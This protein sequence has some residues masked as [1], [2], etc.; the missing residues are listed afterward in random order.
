MGRRRMAEYMRGNLRRIETNL[1]GGFPN[2]IEDRNK[3]RPGAPVTL[4]S[5]A[6]GIEVRMNGQ[7]L[8]ARSHGVVS[9]KNLSSGLNV[10]GH[11]IG[12][13]LVEVRP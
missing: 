11:L 7:V 8:T 6:S 1:G 9:V 5:R 2:D 4:L 12:P 10:T 13:G 3:L